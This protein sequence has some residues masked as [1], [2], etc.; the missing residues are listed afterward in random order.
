[1]QDHPT[2]G[3]GLLIEINHPTRG[4]LL[5]ISPCFQSLV[6]YL[7]PNPWFFLVLWPIIY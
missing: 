6:F 4:W 2:K 1:M 5:G 7:Y 3:V